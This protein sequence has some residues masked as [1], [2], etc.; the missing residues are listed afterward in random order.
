MTDK[1]QRPSGPVVA[2]RLGKR[3]CDMVWFKRATLAAAAIIL[4]DAAL[5]YGWSEWLLRRDQGVPL[6]A[7]TADRSAAGIAEGARLAAIEGCT[8]CHAGGHG[9]VF[10]AAPLFATLVAPAFPALAARA[11]DAQLARA[12]R[13]GV[14][15]DGRQ[16][17]IMPPHPA[18]ADEDAARIIGW[19]RTLRPSPADVP[20]RRGFGP[21]GRWALVTGHAPAT[22]HLPLT[23]GAR[24]PPDAGAYFATTTCLGCHR[25]YEAHAINPQETA[26]PLATMA[27]AYDDARFRRLLRT[28]VGPGKP[29]LGLMSEVAR[30]G[31]YRLSD[32][33]IAAIHAWLT[34]QAEKAPP[35]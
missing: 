4:L 9:Q 7:V 17:F 28:G 31:L 11:S 27:A 35:E 8:I 2:S 19:M 6:H 32:A 3:G 12:I 1:D 34:V 26:P 25:L 29:D 24:R 20:P 22:P 10:I 14:S 15:V 5:L 16:L 33:E 21:L 23:G 30:G 18:L 13:Q